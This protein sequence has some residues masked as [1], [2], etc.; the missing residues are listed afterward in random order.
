M[1]LDQ[2]TAE[3]AFEAQDS[4]ES[5]MLGLVASRK[6]CLDHGVELEDYLLDNV[7]EYESSLLID[8]ADLLAWLGY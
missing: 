8:A 7:L 5:I 6:I 4:G 3:Q 2:F 1:A